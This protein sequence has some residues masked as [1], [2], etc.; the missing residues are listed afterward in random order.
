MLS[1]VPDETMVKIQYKIK[2]GK[3]LNLNDPQLFSEKL[4]AYKLYY[5]DPVMIR[6]VDKYDVKAYLSEKGLGDIVVPTYG[7]YDSADEIDWNALP[8]KFVIKDTLGGGGTAVIIV[9]D[10]NN[11]D[12]SEIKK[13]TSEWVSIN[14][15]GK[16]AGREWPYYSGKQHRIIIEKYLEGAGDEGLVDYK[17]FCFDG[18]V[19]NVMVCV[20]RETGEPKFYFFDEKWNL[21]RLNRRGKAAPEGFTLPKPESMDRMFGLAAELSKGFPFVRVDLYTCGGKIYFGEM[22]FFPASGYDSNIL[23]EADVYL[24]KLLDVSRF[25]HGNK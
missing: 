8:E 5:R 24:G 6:C 11:A 15:H 21:L 14:A 2:M 3:S 22:T 19:D 25:V 1:F 17:F 12:F 13:R 23:P 7:I 16:D 9:T 10:K 20:E 4:Q 18:K